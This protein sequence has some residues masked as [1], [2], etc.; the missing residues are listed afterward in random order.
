MQNK[1]TICTGSESRK[2][3]YSTT[4]Q[5]Y[6]EINTARCHG[7]SFHWEKGRSA[8]WTGRTTESRRLPLKL[9]TGN[10]RGD[11][12]KMNHGL[13]LLFLLLILKP[14]I[15]TPVQLSPQ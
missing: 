9:E 12:E 8:L 13:I 4:A 10:P 1:E 7:N 3:V 5:F 2:R 15:H 6:W 14:L 11:L